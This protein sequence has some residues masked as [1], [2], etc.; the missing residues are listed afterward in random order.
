YFYVATAVNASGESTLSTQASATPQAQTNGGVTITASVGG[1]SPW[2]FE[3]RLS[4]A[5]TASI[6]NVVVTIRVARTTGVTFNGSYETVGGFTKTNTNTASGT[7]IAFTFTRAASLGAG[8]GRLFVA[9]T[10]GSGTAHPFT[11]DSWTVTYTVGTQPFTLSGTF[12]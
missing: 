4:I 9:Q 5:N 2:Y 1:S 7:P 8:T 3:N 6:S 10:N 12:P 11:G